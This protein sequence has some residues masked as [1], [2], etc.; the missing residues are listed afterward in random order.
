MTVDPTKMTLQD[1]QAPKTATPPA[2]TVPA[3]DPKV[4]Q[5][6][7]IAQGAANATSAAP[8]I[9]SRVATAAAGA[10]QS[11]GGAVAD[12]AR[13][14]VEPGVNHFDSVKQ[15]NAKNFTQQQQ[16][17][18]T[19]AQMAGVTVRG[20]ANDIAAPFVA[21]AAATKDIAGRMAGEVTGAWQGVKNFG[22]GLVGLQPPAPAQA[23]APT[24][25]PAQAPAQAAA[26]APVQAAAPAPAGP[27]KE[28]GYAL[29]E[30]AQKMPSAGT[31]ELIGWQNASRTPV[32]DPYSGPAAAA[33]PAPVSASSGVDDAK[34]QLE[35]ILALR[36]DTPQGGFNALPDT[37]EEYNAKKDAEYRMADMI[38]AMKRAGSPQLA[39]G[40]ASMYRQK[41]AGETSKDTAR[42][43]QQGH[44]SGIGMQLPVT[45]RGQD[46][47][48]ATA[49]AGQGIQ[50]RGQDIQAS[51]A[52]AGQD[53]QARGQDIH[54][55][56]SVYNTDRT[57][58]SQAVIAAENNK[59][60]ERRAQLAAD[61]SAN[62]ANAHLNAV[63]YGV[64][65][66]GVQ[67]LDG[68]QYFPGMNAVYRSGAGMVPGLY[69]VNKFEAPP[70]KK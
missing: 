29:P 27:A 37:N 30:L 48:A 15:M 16:M 12:A 42:I 65:M 34:R 41:L 45:M 32:S 57:T 13:G 24:Q 8:G 36:A 68:S 28:N 56:T 19:P 6:T 25:A 26:P 21:G 46:I 67:L 59:A 39:E 52:R 14:M 51:T 4:Q 1:M 23:P 43:N 22:A 3:V 18:A 38:D 2:V 44:L 47:Q 70:P 49:R 62:T 50:A 11:V 17:A 20:A 69:P 61:A 60:A 31:Q 54:A 64:G 9:D 5:I 40:I 7:N 58:N 10:A 33:S 35:N 63:K 66:K 55:A 53:V